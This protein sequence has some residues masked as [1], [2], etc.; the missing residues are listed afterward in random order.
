MRSSGRVTIRQVAYQIGRNH[1]G[2]HVHAIVD[3]ITISFYSTNTGELLIE[4]PLP[5][6]GVRYV[7]NG[8]PRG[9]HQASNPSPKSRDMNCYQSPD[10]ELSPITR[11]ITP[12]LADA[13]IAQ[14][15]Q[16]H[17]G[18]TLG[19]D[20]RA[21]LTAIVSSGRMLDLLIGPAGAGKTTALRALRRGWEAEHRHGSVVGLAPSAVDA[22]VLAGDLGIPTENTAK[23][24]QTY[25]NRGIG[26][27]DVQL[28]IVDGASLAGT[29]ALDRL[30]RIAADA[31]TKVLL[32]GDTA[33]LRSVDAGVAFGLL[34]ADRDDVPELTDVR[35]IRAAWEN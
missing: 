4:H 20:Q 31:G 12:R 26:F 28:V 10:T 25:R 1:A 32:V 8:R 16:P 7:G 23:W 29:L 6:P 11:H 27:T 18:R 2:Q 30:V 35:R 19:S 14:A 13:T 5:A 15:L 24:W 34:V 22:E 17:R 21:A 3:E 33:Q 9:P